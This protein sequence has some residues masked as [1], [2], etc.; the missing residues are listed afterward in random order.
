MHVSTLPGT[1][2]FT[3]G[4]LSSDGRDIAAVNRST[5]DLVLYNRSTASTRVLS[6]LADYPRWSPDGKFVYFNDLYFSASGRNGGVER[7]NASTNT[8]EILLKFPN[9]L[10]TGAYGV[11]FSLTPDG[12]ILLVQDTS[13]RDLY[14]LD[15]DLP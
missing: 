7:W 5:H 8:I 15:L 12:S 4:Q 11:T 2:G 6:G 1:E 10:L 13:N 9:F 14:S 3:Y